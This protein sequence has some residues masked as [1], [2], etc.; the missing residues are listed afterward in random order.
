MFLES[1]VGWR[2]MPPC[3]KESWVESD[4]T[5][6]IILQ[7]FYIFLFTQPHIDFL[8][9][10]ELGVYFWTLMVGTTSLPLDLHRSF[11]NLTNT[12]DLHH[13]F[14]P[15]HYCSQ[16]RSSH[17]LL[18]HLPHE[19][20]VCKQCK[21]GTHSHTKQRSSSLK[22]NKHNRKSTQKHRRA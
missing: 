8:G 17:V 9:V 22:Q 11:E 15:V 21:T 5:N 4:Y 19:R 12:R 2:T 14:T 1:W 3:L 7:I 20:H 18:W 10:T 6:L 13:M 16:L